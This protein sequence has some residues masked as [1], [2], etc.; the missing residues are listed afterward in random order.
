MKER[1]ENTIRGTMRL[2]L[3]DNGNVFMSAEKRRGLHT[4]LYYCGGHK[5]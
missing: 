1:E 3:L 2:S 5:I 4:I